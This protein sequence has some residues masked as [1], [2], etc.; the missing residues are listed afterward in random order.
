MDCAEIL[1]D[2]SVDHVVFVRGNHEDVNWTEFVASW[3]NEQRPLIGL[4][5]SACV[6]GPLVMVGF[7]CM[8]GSESR[9]CSHLP[10]NSDRM[11]LILSKSR[12]PLPVET[13]AWLPQ[14]LRKTGPA[15]RTLWLM[16]ESPMGLPITNPSIQNPIWTSAVERFSPSLVING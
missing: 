6:I 8:T 7:P 14:L 12:E 16:H 5:G 3:P 13:D 15:G 10:A 1:A 11:E 2:L 4:Y 9:W